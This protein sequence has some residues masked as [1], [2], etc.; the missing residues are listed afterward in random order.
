MALEVVREVMVQAPADKV[1][2]A[3][4]GFGS[5]DAWH[6]AIASCEVEEIDGTTH[7]RLKTVDGGELMEKLLAHDDASMAYTYSIE[8]SP[9]PVKG[10]VAEVR[11]A[12]EGEG[13]RLTWSSRFLPDGVGD[14][15]ASAVIA[16]IYEAG[17][18]NVQTMLT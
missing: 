16:G 2:S 11:V 9:L 8:S 12:A 17:L 10:Y 1:W 5:L 4:G 7:R 3:V 14:D 15:E 13:A 18:A 6:P